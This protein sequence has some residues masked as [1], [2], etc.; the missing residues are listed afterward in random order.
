MSIVVP[1]LQSMFA[2]DAV[3]TM[4]MLLE[5]LG[6]EWDVAAETLSRDNQRLRELLSQAR[7]AIESL[8]P[9]D[10]ELKGL[11]EQI[12]KGLDEAPSPSLALSH[13][14]ADNERLRALLER[15]LVA[16]EDAADGPQWEPLLDVRGEIYRHLRE[17]AARGWSFWDALSFRERMAQLRAGS[18]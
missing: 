9:Q 12:G 18:V 5:S 13:L 8:S 16:C 4:Q 2:Q 3:Q 7:A 14:T 11:S 1:E 6:N 15:V 10:G 17:V